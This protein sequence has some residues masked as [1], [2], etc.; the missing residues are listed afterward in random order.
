MPASIPDAV[1]AV[2]LSVESCF[3]RYIVAWKHVFVFALFP[4]SN[5]SRLIDNMSGS[6]LRLHPI[7]GFK[8]CS[9][10]VEFLRTG[11]T[12]RPSI[13]CF[14]PSPGGAQQGLI[15]LGKNSRTMIA[16]P[17][18]PRVAAHV[19]VER[20]E[21][22]SVTAS[23]PA[24]P[25]VRPS[26]A[27]SMYSSLE[28][29]LKRKSPPHLMKLRLRLPKYDKGFVMINHQMVR[30]DNP[31]VN[32]GDILSLQS[33]SYSYD[34]VVLIHPMS[35]ANIANV[36]PDAFFDEPLA[37]ISPPQSQL[38]VPESAPAMADATPKDP[39]AVTA[40]ASN[41]IVL[42][43]AQDEFTCA[44]CLEYQ[45]QSTTLVPCGHSFCHSCI[46]NPTSSKVKLKSC[47]VCNSHIYT[48]VPNRTID[49]CLNALTQPDSSSSSLEQSLLPEDDVAYF[50]ERL[51]ATALSNVDRKCQLT[52]HRTAKRQRPTSSRTSHHSRRIDY[53][54]PA[55]FPLA[56]IVPNQAAILGIVRS[57]ATPS[58]TAPA[59]GDASQVP[60]HGAT[61]TDAIVID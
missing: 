48:I 4:A 1:V 24:A 61:P 30:S 11:C 22:G 56:M 13:D 26:A 31:V 12:E 41:D 52:H 54:D 7:D 40:T 19:I 36:L 18:L 58:H 59:G 25:M 6:F 60:R 55:S 42:R 46:W 21:Q 32:E 57:V 35:D 44:I 37:T 51:A 39:A 3:A 47:S 45:V 43:M 29:Q 33:L 5:R 2:A 49:N 10:G 8:R 34:Y 53:N 50:K 20:V 28:Q 14:L 16:D 9:N 27:P 38:P 17:T 23:L 15:A